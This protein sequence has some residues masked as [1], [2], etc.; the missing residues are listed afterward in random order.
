MKKHKVK[1]FMT[2]QSVLMVILLGLLA[3]SF[4]QIY[5]SQF[6]ALTANRRALQAQ[7]FAQSE[8]D[9]LRNVS[10][11]EL[12]TIVHG[13]QAI[14]GTSGWMSE[15]SLSAETTVN[16]VQ[17]R[18][19]TI[20]VYRNSSVSAPDFSLQVPLTSQ[21]SGND[22]KFDNNGYSRLPSGLIIQW[23]ITRG[24]YKQQQH[25][26]LPK[27]MPHRL[28]SVIISNSGPW[29]GHGGTQCDVS[30]FN[31]SQTG[32]DYFIFDDDFYFQHSFLAIG[33]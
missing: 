22:N 10:Y 32:F 14:A 21:G 9:F 25:V 12:N 33:Y 28:L 30:T 20:K 7:Q 6:S 27:P 29:S 13:R 5:G 17:Q 1:G 16:E 18:I 11:D 23:G 15:V 2:L 19:G 31:W 26:T 4:L 3:L 24:G 8:A